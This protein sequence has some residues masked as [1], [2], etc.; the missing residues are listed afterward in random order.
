[1]TR[2]TA[3]GSSRP[4][5]TLWSV[6]LQLLP[7]FLLCALFTG[8]GILHVSSRV[9]VVRTGYKLSELEQKNRELVREHDRLRLELATLKSPNRLERIARGE[10]S[11][12]PP[13]P[14]AVVTV[15]D[16]V[17]RLGRDAPARGVR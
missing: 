6:I 14:G 12:S 2:P 16:S 17:Q 13:P 10:L 7:A 3:K 15:K 1:M 8:V 9:L 11:M 5:A 4:G